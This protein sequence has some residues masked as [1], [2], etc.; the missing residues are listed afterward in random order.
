MEHCNAILIIRVA[1]KSLG[2]RLIWFFTWFF[3]WNFPVSESS[4]LPSRSAKESLPKRVIGRS[5][6][7]LIPRHN[8]LFLWLFWVSL[9]VSLAAPESPEIRTSFKSIIKSFTEV[10]CRWRLSCL[11][12]EGKKERNFK[13][14]STRSGVERRLLPTDLA[15]NFFKIFISF[16]FSFSLPFSMKSFHPLKFALIFIRHC[17]N[18][19]IVNFAPFP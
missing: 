5:E 19:G 9:E 15:I 17:M 1:Y 3:T 6:N 12:R 18:L 8:P 4:G 14:F 2:G 11:P 10:Q 13:I 7:S 16:K